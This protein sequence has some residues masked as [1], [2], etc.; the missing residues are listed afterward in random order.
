MTTIWKER[1]LTLIMVTVGCFFYAFGINGFIIP[2]HLISGGISGI[3]LILYYLIGLPVGISNLLLNVP[4][5]YGAYRH[6]GRWY[7]A[8]SIFGTIMF[9]VVI[10]SFA[11]LTDLDFS[12][13]P[14]V[15]AI[16]GGILSGIGGGLMYRYGGNSGG[17]DVIGA[18]V[19]K[20]WGLQIGSVVFI[21]NCIIL[22]L[23]AYLFTVEAAV[24]T[25][26]SIYISAQ[27][28]NKVVTGFNQRKAVFIISYHT[29]GI[30]DVILRHIGRGA[31]ILRGE[32]AYTH[33][34]KQVVL[35]VISLMQVAKLKTAINSVDPTAFMLIT[36]ASEVIGQGFTFKTKA[37]HEAV[38]RQMEE[39]RKCPTLEELKPDD[40]I[41]QIVQGEVTS[42]NPAELRKIVNTIEDETKK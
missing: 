31:T 11:F 5:L 32:G 29:E 2:H 22:L 1:M 20:Y 19:R 33:Q 35:V 40:T 17:M 39:A 41:E 28:S 30:C 10:D 36:D 4:I 16:M 23:S 15:G 7:V 3:A 18:I 24:I 12:H 38:L 9:S 26:I 42:S 21:V 8:V 37:T 27:L 34:E 6:L 13:N 14:I 25:L